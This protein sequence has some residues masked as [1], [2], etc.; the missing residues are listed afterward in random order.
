[1]R[2]NYADRAV[3]THEWLYM[4][5]P[6][7]AISTRGVTRDPLPSTEWNDIRL[8]LRETYPG[9]LGASARRK[10]RMIASSGPKLFA[11]TDEARVYMRIPSPP[12]RV[13]RWEDVSIKGEKS[14]DL[15]DRGEFLTVT[16]STGKVY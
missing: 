3:A 9:G 15:R 6:D 5:T 4:L 13:V 11:L 10:V 14:I 16:T 2:A 1:M 7:G 12:E 8:I